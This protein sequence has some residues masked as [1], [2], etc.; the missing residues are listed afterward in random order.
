[1]NCQALPADS[2]MLRVPALQVPCPFP[3]LSETS[4]CNCPA[5][6]AAGQAMG[7]FSGT[8]LLMALRAGTWD[9]PSGGGK[10]REGSL[11]PHASWKGKGGREDSLGTRDSDL[12][13]T[14]EG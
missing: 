8:S 11:A 6:G 13:P 4:S 2:L 14:G 10:G 12:C 7:S 9:V 1:M 3:E 5:E